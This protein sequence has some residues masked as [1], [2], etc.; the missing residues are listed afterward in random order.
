MGLMG[1][2][3][4][5]YPLVMAGGIHIAWDMT[6]VLPF[7]GLSHGH[8]MYGN[9]AVGLPLLCSLGL[10]IGIFDEIA[11][12]FHGMCHGRVHALWYFANT[13]RQDSASNYLSSL[14][15]LRFVLRAL[16]HRRL[17]RRVDIIYAP[18]LGKWGQVP[19]GTRS[20]WASALYFTSLP[21]DV[22]I[23]NIN[24]DHHTG[25]KQSIIAGKTS[26]SSS[27]HTTTG[28]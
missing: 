10:A 25:S 2:P 15:L 24:S 13:Y 21:S 3:V 1:F 14:A 18:L 7:R 4:D 11:H 17:L 27:W 5:F 9:C 26:L 28:H 23:T 12:G 8:H 19:N 20:G 22:I 6:W 16:G